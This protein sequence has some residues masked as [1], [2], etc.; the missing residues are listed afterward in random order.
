M[1]LSSICHGPP[2]AWSD[3]CSWIVAFYWVVNSFI[4]G[5]AN[6]NSNGHCYIGSI[7]ILFKERSQSGYL[8]SP[9]D[10]DPFALNWL[11][12]GP[13]G[14]LGRKWKPQVYTGLSGVPE[15]GENFSEGASSNDAS[16][17]ASTVPKRGGNVAQVAIASSFALAAFV[18]F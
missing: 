8:Q 11:T 17:T 13:T 9:L 5:F 18:V 1:Q 3:I 6:L 15:D 2:P 16:S 10:D 4:Y 12:S 14:S 7:F